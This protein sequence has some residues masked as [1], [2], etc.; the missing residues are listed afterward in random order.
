M[1]TEKH[2]VTHIT[3]ADENIFADLGFPPD[4]AEK[5]LAEADRAITNRIAIKEALM[6]E[7][8]SWILVQKL[9]QVEAA[10]QLGISRPRVSDVVNKKTAN[11]T[12]DALV[13]MLS[14]LGKRV[15]VSII[16]L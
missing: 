13:E 1:I 15:D 8:S 7:I 10:H 14:R 9:K 4:I 5:L 2:G 11:F 12:I 3:P 6:T 16:D